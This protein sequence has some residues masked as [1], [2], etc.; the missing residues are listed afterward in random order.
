MLL[1]VAYLC[2]VK[3]KLHLSRWIV[4]KYI[5]SSF[6]VYCVF[7]LFLIFF[8]NVSFFPFKCSP[9]LRKESRV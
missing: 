3:S 5:L 7:Y 2:S 9:V 1:M 6:F 8:F 4:S